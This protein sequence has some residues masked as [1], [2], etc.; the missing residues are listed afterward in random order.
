MIKV[1]YYIGTC[2]KGSCKKELLDKDFYKMFDGLFGDYTLQKAESVY[3]MR[4]TGIVVKEETF[5]VTTLIDED[6]DNKITY[7]KIY[8]NVEIMKSILNQASILV[9]VTKPEVMFI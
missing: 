4:D 2:D 1:T 3:T 8:N 9:K 7:Y 6:N 5:I